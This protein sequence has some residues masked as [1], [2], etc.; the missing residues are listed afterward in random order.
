MLEDGD[1]MRLA[2]CLGVN[3]GSG[4]AVEWDLSIPARQTGV[5]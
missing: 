3:A 1:S 4:G 2:M 5:T